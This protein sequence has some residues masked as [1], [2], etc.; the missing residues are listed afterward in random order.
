MTSKRIEAANISGFLRKKKYFIAFISAGFFGAGLFYNIP[1]IAMWLGFAF[2]A[3]SVVAN[4]S[5]QTIGTFIASNRD[6]KWWLLWLFISAIFLGTVGYSWVTY[7]GDVTYQRLASKGLSEAP[8]EFSYLQ[9]TAPLFLLILTRLKIPVSTTFLILSCF[10]TS[11][12][13]IA[14]IVA[15]S[16]SGYFIAFATAF[17]L[18]FL[19]TKF[20]KPRTK[21][22]KPIHPGWRVAQ[23]ASTG[24]LWSIWLMQDAS[25][26]AVFLPRS[27]GSGGFLAFSAVV[28]AGLGWLFYKRGERI[29]EVVEEKS[30][31]QDIKAATTV[32]F[33][34]AAILYIFKIQSSVPMS[35]TW[36]FVGLLAGR[37]IA[38]GLTHSNE[39]RGLRE[40]VAIS[41]RDFGYV[42]LGLG[43]S[44][45]LAVL[46]NN[47]IR[48]S[49]L[50]F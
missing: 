37:E 2:A 14:A 48:Q 46:S 6:V 30:R 23:W 11:A 33:I 41:A 21:E 29:Q 22:G 31:I 4:D 36:V 34:Y 39:K 8:T 20:F 7:G 26:V 47:I 28:V 35:T 49:W 50:G 32:D 1:G 38:K 17:A 27:L 25:N 45:L 12:T 19:I 40:A 42:T 3:Y 9:V 16:V 15:K 24:T 44:L 5:I 10:A 18:W 43:I 13:T